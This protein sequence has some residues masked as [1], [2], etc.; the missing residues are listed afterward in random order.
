VFEALSRS[1]LAPE[2]G[3]AIADRLAQMI[4]AASK[5]T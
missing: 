1:R 5:T 3:Q 2:V 4:A